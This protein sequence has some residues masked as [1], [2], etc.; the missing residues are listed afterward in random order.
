MPHHKRRVCILASYTHPSILAGGSLEAVWVV[1]SGARLWR[2][3]TK[4]STKET[5]IRVQRNLSKVA[6]RNDSLS[7]PGAE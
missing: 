6:Y 5:R 3:W 7:W 4:D 1:E 2:I